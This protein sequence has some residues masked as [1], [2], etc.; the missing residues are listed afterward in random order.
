MFLVNVLLVGSLLLRVSLAGVVVCKNRLEAAELARL[1]GSDDVL[2]RAFYG[3]SIPSDGADAEDLEVE[4]DALAVELERL[5]MLVSVHD[6]ERLPNLVSVQLWPALELDQ[7]GSDRYNPATPQALPPPHPGTLY[8]DSDGLAGTVHG[9]AWIASASPC[10]PL[11]TDGRARRD[12]LLPLLHEL[13]AERGHFDARAHCD[14]ANHRLLRDPNTNHMRCQ[15]PEGKQC[16][17]AGYKH[18][19]LLT[20]LAVLVVL[21]VVFAIV[22]LNAVAIQQLDRRFKLFAERKVS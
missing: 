1:A 12:A 7:R 14:D 6:A 19:V 13:V 8:Y 11:F 10:S 16:G 4:R 18:N 20:I 15:C 21:L 2:V 22:A 3:L 9:S 17:N 5:N